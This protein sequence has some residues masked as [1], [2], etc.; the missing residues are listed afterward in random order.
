M[1]TKLR[2]EWTKEEIIRE[3]RRWCSG[4]GIEFDV[5]IEW[6]TLNLTVR[7]G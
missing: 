6:R 7:I 4:K 3:V 1:I 2:S 5:T